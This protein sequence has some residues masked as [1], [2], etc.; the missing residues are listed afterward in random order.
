MFFRG[1]ASVSGSGLGLYILKE[2]VEKLNGMV[3]VE[4]EEGVGTT[5][6]ITIPKSQ[7]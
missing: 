5:F 1:S 7:N 3:S 6:K 2:S 4:S